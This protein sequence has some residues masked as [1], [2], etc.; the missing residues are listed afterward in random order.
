MELVEFL[1]ARIAEDEEA[2]RAALRKSS[3][4]WSDNAFT[5][6]VELAEGEGAVK[7]ATSHI[8]RW[9]P[10]RVLAECEAKRQIVERFRYLNGPHAV[11]PFVGYQQD[12]AGQ[13]AA[14]R[15]ALKALTLPYVDHPDYQ[16]EWK[17]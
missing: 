2:A 1:L 4:E 13:V 17:P 14:L 7:E 12:E 3:Y 10:A 8:A 16:Q 9:D 6:A 15:L 5:E 11:M